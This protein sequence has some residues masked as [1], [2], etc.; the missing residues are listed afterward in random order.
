[1]NYTLTL[2]SSVHEDPKP[3]PLPT[4]PQCAVDWP[5]YLS[6]TSRSFRIPQ[7]IL[8][9]HASAPTTPW[10]RTTFTTDECSLRDIKETRPFEFVGV[11]AAK[12]I[13]RNTVILLDPD[14]RFIPRVHQSLITRSC[15]TPPRLWRVHNEYVRGSQIMDWKNGV[16]FPC[17]GM[18][19]FRPA[20]STRGGIL[21]F[22]QTPGLSKS[23]NTT[24][25]DTTSPEVF[26]VPNAFVVETQ[27]EQTGIWFPLGLPSNFEIF[28][29]W[30][31][32][33]QQ[34]RPVRMSEDRGHGDFL[35]Q[36]RGT[37]WIHACACAKA[38]YD[39]SID[40]FPA[41]CPT[42][43]DMVDIEQHV[44]FRAWTY[45]PW[46]MTLWLYE[47]YVKDSF[48]RSPDEEA[49]LGR[50]PEPLETL[51]SRLLHTC[52][53][54]DASTVVYSTPWNLIPQAFHHHPTIPTA[55]VTQVQG[56]SHTIALK[57][58]VYVAVEVPSA[59][60]STASLTCKT[61]PSKEFSVK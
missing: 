21:L 7:T 60:S 47:Q 1:M 51:T 13:P 39:E 29:A 20:V 18:D 46:L 32:P 52:I 25:H 10:V 27:A 19:G 37:W 34:S 5:L 9:P 53:G 44:L 35:F 49:A 40:M 43:Y 30:P 61:L 59:P 3:V 15:E 17:R 55:Q 31:R 58:G 28:I 22:A 26:H 56:P 48:P 12:P 45:N 2:C 41:I 6:R 16:E 50:L 57:N 33:P 38:M 4:A 42:T 23:C 54:L 36:G 14:D 8:D 11:F 24:H